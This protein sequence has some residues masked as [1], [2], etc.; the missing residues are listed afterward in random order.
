VIRHLLSPV[1][2]AAF[3]ISSLSTACRAQQGP[4]WELDVT[5][6]TEVHRGVLGHTWEFQL[7]SPLK[8]HATVMRGVAGGLAAE[9]FDWRRIG[10]KESGGKWGS[11]LQFLRQ[12]RD[13]NWDPMITVNLR[14]LRDPNRGGQFG[15]VS[16]DMLAQL[17]A[18]WVRYCNH[19]V[20]KY[21]RGDVIQD[22]QDRRIVESIAWEGEEVLLEPGE[23]DVPRVQR[24]EIG[25]EPSA[26]AGN[27]PG[28]AGPH[29]FTH[30]PDD[31]VLRYKTI[32]RAMV[33]ADPAIKVG[34]CFADDFRDLA[35][36]PFVM[37]LLNS[38][39]R[40]DFLS[41]HKYA[42][43]MHG[44]PDEGIM[45]GG[46]Q[47]LRRDMDDRHTRCIDAIV[48]SGRDPAKIELA[49]TEYNAASWGVNSVQL[50]MARA[51]GTSVYLHQLIEKG[52]HV[53]NHWDRLAF[54]NAP[55]PTALLMQSYV[56]DLGA[57]CVG[58]YRD[59]TVDVIATRDSES[60][61]DLTLWAFNLDPRES[62]RVSLRIKG[63]ATIQSAESSTLQATQGKT[64][65][66]SRNTPANPEEVAW[67][68]E[69]TYK[70]GSNGLIDLEVPS[71]TVR[72][73][74][75]RAA[76]PQTK[77]EPQR[78]PERRPTGTTR[79]ATTPDAVVRGAPAPLNAATDVATTTS[80]GVVHLKWKVGRGSRQFIERCDDDIDFLQI[81]E[82]SAN[83][84]QFRDVKVTPGNSYQYRVVTRAQDG[85]SAYSGAVRV[86]VQGK[87]DSKQAA[88]VEGATLAQAT[89][90]ANWPFDQAHG[91]A[92]LV[93][94]GA[95]HKVVGGASITSTGERQAVMIP[96]GGYVEL[97]DPP[98]FRV[99]PGYQ[100]TL[101]FWIKTT[102]QRGVILAKNE[103]HDAPAAYEYGV[104]LDPP[105]RV[106]WM[107][108]VHVRGFKTQIGAS[109]KAIAD[110]AWHHVAITFQGPTG[111]F[112]IDG[113]PSGVFHSLEHNVPMR[114]SLLI[115]AN[116][117]WRPDLINP[118]I[119][120]EL[121]DLRFYDQALAPAAVGELSSKTR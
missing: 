57:I 35:G 117:T 45:L 116:R 70:V 47:E 50:S 52:Y 74:R 102:A 58:R 118:G 17:A 26:F 31:Y 91:F 53:A 25:N 21:R 80:D 97:N 44:W 15:D 51:L 82:L 77:V 33:E 16:P 1:L 41:Y 107:S 79:P 72:Q 46:L 32:T 108:A 99:G 103:A 48:A 113:E 10:T 119:E 49:L 120:M 7:Q 92:N 81:A 23:A 67:T 98:I 60:G 110:G 76:M 9:N 109:E 105:G 59:Q 94:R 68:E 2:I 65:L 34:P 13:E 114:H 69:A 18:D 4:V 121:S 73:W 22:A 39:A 115:G 63:V 8:A 84:T 88:P 24:W 101:S 85:R 89:L 54:D 90:L 111:R 104:M 66:H 55:W 106:R 56:R 83:V 29:V 42:H 62:R 30:R 61:S 28:G 87:G 100:G 96:K 12:C 93:Q 20:P 3:I 37:A 19:I 40:I 11:T 27:L 112:Y 75:I 38:D 95:S 86:S 6:G 14:G 64:K 71:L 5:R 43:L 78:F 36:K